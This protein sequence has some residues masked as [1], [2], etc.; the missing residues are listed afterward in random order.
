[1][2]FPSAG[3]WCAYGLGS[4]SWNLPGY[5]VL[6]SGN[7]VPP[8]GG[9]SLFSN[10]FLPAEY[11]GSILR[12]DKPD[13][14]RNIR[15][16]N[17]AAAQRQR[18]DFARTFDNDFLVASSGDAQVEAAIR[19]YETAFR[20]QSAVPELCDISGEKK[21]LTNSTDWTPTIAKKPRT[22][23]SACWLVV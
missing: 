2:G 1:M 20:M 6:Q 11:Q 14:I 5:V 9:V 17:T 3:A 15:A 4:D 12:A 18:L 19:N 23:G 10:G 7:A 16:L 13:A 21:R 8:H 22:R